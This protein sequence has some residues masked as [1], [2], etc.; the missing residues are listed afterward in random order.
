[1]AA[2]LRL[3]EADARDPS[4]LFWPAPR[5]RV[6]DAVV[7]ALES[8]EFLRQSRVIAETWAKAGVQTR[9]ED[10]AGTNHFTVLDHLRDPQSAMVRRLAELA[11]AEV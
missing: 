4:P 2:D 3:N 6:F 9:Y 10:I 8:A 7:G 11:R 1:M 5:G